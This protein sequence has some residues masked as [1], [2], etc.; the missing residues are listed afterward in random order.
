LHDYM[1]EIPK[2]ELKRLEERVRRESG[3]R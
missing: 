2:E 1:D 3:Q